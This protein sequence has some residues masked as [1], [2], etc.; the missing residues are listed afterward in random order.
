[1]PVPELG[2]C[3]IVRPETVRASGVFVLK[4]A[5]I[6]INHSIHGRITDRTVIGICRAVES[7]SAGNALAVIRADRVDATAEVLADN[8]IG[9]SGSRT[10]IN[11]LHASLAGESIAALARVRIESVYAHC[12][13]V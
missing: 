8:I 5:C 11:I 7:V 2:A 12:R 6:R 13:L 10:F 4:D 9:G 3:T 1:L